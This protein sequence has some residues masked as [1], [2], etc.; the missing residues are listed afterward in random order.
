[1]S[2]RA[3]LWSSPELLAAAPPL[4]LAFGTLLSL[5]W[6]GL[7]LKGDLLLFPLP[8]LLASALVIGGAVLGLVGYTGLRRPAW[9][10]FVLST[11]SYLSVAALV[12]DDSSSAG[13]LVAG[14]PLAP[15]FRLGWLVLAMMFAISVGGRDT[16][17]ALWLF[18][19]FLSAEVTHF[20]VLPSEPVFLVKLSLAGAVLA[21]SLAVAWAIA[22]FTR[23][24]E[25]VAFWVVI[26][27][28]VLHP[29]LVVWPLA[30]EADGGASAYIQYG[31]S[32]AVF[33]GVIMAMT[34]ALHRLAVGLRRRME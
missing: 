12:G 4:V 21:E 7:G 32:G 31:V 16:R 13:V 10:V 28:L 29:F 3:S 1:M 23:G 25:R 24:V 19:L 18:A 20:P 30:F 27:L 14:V 22:A 11:L 34:F 9:G 2:A 15:F 8:T 26:L 17:R 5:V 6:R 33:L